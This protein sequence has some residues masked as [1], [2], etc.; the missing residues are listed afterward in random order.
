M[1]VRQFLAAARRPQ[2]QPEFIEISGLLDLGEG[3]ESKID[4]RKTKIA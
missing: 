2:K 4:L 3:D 1:R